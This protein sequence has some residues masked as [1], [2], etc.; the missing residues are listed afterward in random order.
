MP[1]EEKSRT[2]SRDRSK[3]AQDRARQGGVEIMAED[4]IRQVEA[5]A[6]REHATFNVT[7][8]HAT[9]PTSHDI[10][11]TRVYHEESDERSTWP[12]AA[13]KQ[14]VDWMRE[15]AGLS[16]DEPTRGAL[17]D[18]MG[19][20]TTTGKPTDIQVEISSIQIDE[21]MAE[22]E[23]SGPLK[24]KRL[25]IQM[26]F[27]L[28]SMATYLVITKQLRYAVHLLAYDLINGQTTTLTSERQELFPEPT[29]GYTSSVEFEMP[30]VGQ[31]QLMATIMLPDHDAAGVLLGPVLTVVA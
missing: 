31:Y 11:Q 17:D 30:E 22:Q 9:D 3:S 8:N 27:Q 4:A 1:I 29:G 15:K 28:S 18:I 21:V 14:I 24:T 10:W 13:G 26:D 2:K 5:I 7:F 12:G 19:D 23:V 6:W 20:L 25:R 16:D